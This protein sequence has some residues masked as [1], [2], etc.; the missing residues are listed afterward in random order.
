[1]KNRNFY[2]SFLNIN[3]VMF[4]I[5]LIISF[6]VCCVNNTHAQSLGKINTIVLDA[7][8]GGSDPGNLGTGTKK[9]TEKDITLDVTLMLGAYIEEQFPEIKIVY[10][11]KTDVAVDLHERPKI[12]NDAK[13]DLFISIHC[14]S[15]QPKPEV[16]GSETFVMG[17]HKSEDNLRVAQNENSV[18]FLEKDYQKHYEGFDPKSPESMIALMMKQN[19]YLD[20]SLLLSKEI[21]DQFRDRVSRH[22]RGVKQAGFWVISYTT[23]PSVLVELGFLT[24]KKEEN[25]L[26]SETGKDYMASALFRAFK[27]YKEKIEGLNAKV[28]T[29]IE[30]KN[31]L[32][33]NVNFK[34]Q[35]LSSKQ[36]V[37]KQI[38]NF[39]GLKKIDFYEDNGWFKY[40]YGSTNDYHA[41][42]NILKEVK[43]AGYKE[44]F[45]VAFLNNKR[46]SVKEAVNLIKQNK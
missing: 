36:K 42:K 14:N 15:Y 3:K 28:N 45:V 19:A 27:S 34:V 30:D 20:Q 9:V 33:N 16:H 18:M 23:M 38:D 1:M 8:H 10:T 26:N 39:R 11:R 4:P 31:K 35:F 12:A 13:A 25:F 43:T 2:P 32:E 17:L 46:I 41:V 44:A 21:Q 37:A 6:V 29:S 5:T 40:T 7:G 24:N 22:D